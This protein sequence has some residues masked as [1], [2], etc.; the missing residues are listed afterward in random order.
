VDDRTALE[1]PETTAQSPM[2]LVVLPE[3]H[4]FAV[5]PLNR[6]RWESFKANRRGYW[7]L[8]IFLVLFVVSLFAEFIANDK[9]FYVSYD[10][11]SYFPVLVTYPETTFGGDFET[12]ADYRD[13]FLNPHEQMQQLKEHPTVAKLIEGGK[14]VGLKAQTRFW[15]YSLTLPT[16]ESENVSVQVEGAVDQSADSQDMTPLQATRQWVSQAETNVIDRLVQ[17]GLLAPPSDFDK[18]LEQIVVNLAVP[19]NLNFPD[20][21]HCRILLTI[22]KG[23]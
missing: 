11:K 7:A 1:V 22:K 9:P 17:A 6:R 23:Y 5:S 18:T 16:R 14:T 10:G 4:R 15:G 8:W 2:G 13:P 19:N 3:G 20:P 21:V 12:A